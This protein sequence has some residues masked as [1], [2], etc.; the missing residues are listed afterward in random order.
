MSSSNKNATKENKSSKAKKVVKSSTN[1]RYIKPI[2]YFYAVL[3]LVGG[4][5]LVWFIFNWYNIKREEQ[6][7][8]SYLISSNTIESSITDINTLSL[9]EQEA[10]SAYF[11]YISYTKDKNVYNFEKE[12]KKLIDKYKLNDIFYY[13][14]LTEYKEKNIDCLNLVK[15]KLN[16][17]NI[18][19]LPVIIYFENNIVKDVVDGGKNAQIKIADVKKILKNNNFEAVN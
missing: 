3:V 13:L 14:D 17:N 1:E 5:A 6:L 10:P 4:I 18:N 19:D 8:V 11:I 7:M 9:I 2:N 16:I 15:E 12:L